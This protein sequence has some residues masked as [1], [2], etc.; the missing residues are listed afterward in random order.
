MK[1]LAIVS[2]V[3]ACWICAF[4]LFWVYLGMVLDAFVS[5]RVIGHWPTQQP[6]DSVML[7]NQSRWTGVAAAVI[8]LSIAALSARATRKFDGLPRL[9][10]AVAAM[11]VLS[12]LAILLMRIDPGDITNW[13]F[14]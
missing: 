11:L 10:I 1:R 2:A 4:L 9:A 12:G 5:W 7:H 3:Y 6:Y 8:C 13:A 14:D